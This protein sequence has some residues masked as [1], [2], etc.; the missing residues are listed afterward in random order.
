[1]NT[2]DLKVHF[3]V[4]LATFSEYGR[5]SLQNRRVKTQTKLFFVRARS[6]IFYP[7]HLGNVEVSVTYDLRDVRNSLRERAREV[8]SQFS[9][10]FEP[11]N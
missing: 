1:M 2:T 7:I 10:S 8:T 11:L 5:K 9:L 6:A 4:F 3:L